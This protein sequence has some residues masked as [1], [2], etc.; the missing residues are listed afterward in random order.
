M[1]QQRDFFLHLRNSSLLFKFSGNKIRI[2]IHPLSNVV[3]IE[4]YLVGTNNAQINVPSNSILVSTGKILEN[5]Y[6]FSHLVALQSE[7]INKFEDLTKWLLP[8]LDGESNE[9]FQ[10]TKKIKDE[11]RMHNGTYWRRNGLYISMKY[12]LHHQMIE[13]VGEEKGEFIYKLLILSFHS[14]ILRKVD[15][16]RIEYG[17]FNDIVLK[18][19][20]RVEKLRNKIRENEIFREFEDFI[21]KIEQRIHNIYSEMKE[22]F[23]SYVN[24]LPSTATRIDCSGSPLELDQKLKNSLE[25]INSLNIP[26]FTAITS[27]IPTAATPT[28]VSDGSTIKVLVKL[29]QDAQNVSTLCKTSLMSATERAVNG[30]WK[31]NNLQHQVSDLFELFQI[32]KEQIPSDPVGT[33]IQYLTLASICALIDKT[34]LVAYPLFEQH[35]LDYKLPDFSHVILVEK[36][37]LQQLNE[38][39]KYFNA[40][41]AKPLPGILAVDSESAAVKFAQTNKIILEKREEILQRNEQLKQQKLQ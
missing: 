35:K 20:I 24:Q 21:N 22:I 6:F 29:L 15:I 37:Y 11:A 1:E 7:F 25:H 2:D 5:E 23:S 12:I 19:K 33:G 38:V 17:L 4:K 30:W 13:E 27:Y 9:F 36:Q 26:E 18:I 41:N 3:D 39:Q 14:V 16:Q 31:D 32:Y 28:L 40:R 34:I 8:A 10:I